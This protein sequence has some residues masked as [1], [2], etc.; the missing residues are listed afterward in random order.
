M[1]LEELGSSDME[2]VSFERCA[3][4]EELGSE[5]DCSSLPQDGPPLLDEL[6]LLF[7]LYLPVLIAI[8][9]LVTTYSYGYSQ[10]LSIL[11]KNEPNG[12][13]RSIDLL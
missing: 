12:R 10:L 8:I 9:S 3:A 1:S 7:N 2:V 11:Q 13:I 5:V 4:K 6:I